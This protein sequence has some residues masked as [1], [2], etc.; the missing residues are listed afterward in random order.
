M[1]DFRI[2]PEVDEQ[3]GV[4]RRRPRQR[5]RSVAAGQQQPL[6]VAEGQLALP[7]DR[8]VVNRFVA[9]QHRMNAPGDFQ[10]P[11]QFR[12]DEMGD[13]ATER[14][15]F[16]GIERQ[17]PA[18]HRHLRAPGLQVGP[19]LEGVLENVFHGPRQ[20]R[21]RR[22]FWQRGKKIRPAPALPLGQWAPRQRLCSATTSPVIVPWRVSHALPAGQMRAGCPS[23]RD[24]TSRE[25]FPGAR[26]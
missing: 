7:P 19:D 10:P 16:S 9:A 12:P 5:L 4:V 6:H 1:V 11:L 24:P 8:I 23:D 20:R 14:G 26:R 17:L 3:P 22:P 2:E 18:L 15:A 25:T 21:A 13:D